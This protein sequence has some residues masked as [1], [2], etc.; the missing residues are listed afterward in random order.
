MKD[1]ICLKPGQ[2]GFINNG[3]EKFFSAFLSIGTFEAEQPTM[4][5][6]REAFNLFSEA[7]KLRM[8]SLPS[9]TR[10]VPS[11]DITGLIS[12]LAV[13]KYLGFPADQVLADFL[14]GLYG[15]RGFDA[16]VGDLKIDVKGTRGPGRWRFSK[17]NRHRDKATSYVF[18]KVEEVSTEVWVTITGFAHRHEIKP[19]VR[20]DARS[21]YVRYETLQREG[22]L[23][24]LKLLKQQT[25][26]QTITPINQ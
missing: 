25:T 24:P 1:I 22:L 12:E 6:S 18:C 11:A 4:R 14:A 23:K 20:E 13:L 19:W 21:Y 5:F 2:K 26:N 10:W 16:E 17:S 3:Q 7:S 8:K 15:D 9:T